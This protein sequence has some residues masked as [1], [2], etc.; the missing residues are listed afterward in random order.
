MFKKLT[1]T[2]KA[3]LGVALAGI[4][5]YFA[6]QRG[7]LGSHPLA[8]LGE[9][10]EPYPYGPEFV[11][12]PPTDINSYFDASTGAVIHFDSSESDPSE[13]YKYTDDYPF[14]QDADDEIRVGTKTQAQFAE[15]LLPIYEVGDPNALIDS[16]AF[17]DEAR[18]Q[19]GQ[20]FKERTIAVMQGLG[21]LGDAYKWRGGN[22]YKSGGKT[23]QG[24]NQFYN[25]RVGGFKKRYRKYNPS[26]FGMSSDRY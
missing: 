20:E 16:L 26:V 17:T 14:M 5:Y 2:H 18:Q 4:G 3:I 9:A 7:M 8:G 19:S 22:Q 12:S 24:G 21:M 13:V 1:A 10:R 6:K 25:K 15:E 23:W 11:Y